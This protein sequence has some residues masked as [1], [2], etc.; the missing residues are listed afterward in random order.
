MEQF[1]SFFSSNEA[2][3]KDNSLSKEFKLC[4]IGKTKAGK[5]SIINVLRGK[6]NHDPGYALSSNELKECTMEFEEFDFE[7]EGQ[8]YHI[9]LVDSKG[10]NNDDMSQDTI[11]KLAGKYDG[12]VFVTNDA[13]LKEDLNLFQNIDKKPLIL[14]FV[15]TR[16]DT[17]L[18]GEL[19]N[20]RDVSEDVATS[21]RETLIESLRKDMKNVL[22]K[23]HI[24]KVIA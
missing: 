24:S 16:F 10:I 11:E 18:D 23:S 7:R 13:L 14:F 15:R 6:Y 12:I 9:K 17:V 19:N 22:I 8:S 21:L 3:K 4:F 20:T 2:N 1:K 5:S